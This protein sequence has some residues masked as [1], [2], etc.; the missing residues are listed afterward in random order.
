MKKMITLSTALMLCSTM[1]LAQSERNATYREHNRFET[2]ERNRGIERP[3]I[4][5]RFYREKERIINEINRKY[6]LKIQSVWNN[7]FMSKRKK[8]RITEELNEDRRREIAIAISKL[9]KSYHSNNYYGNNW[10][11]H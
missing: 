4:A 3:A 11:H 1:M 6:D 5:H 8:Y 10:G 7:W 9:E 2:E